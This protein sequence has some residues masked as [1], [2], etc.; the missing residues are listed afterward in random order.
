MITEEQRIAFKKVC[1]NY[2]TSKIQS[3]LEDNNVKDAKGNTHSASMITNV[4]NGLT[5]HEEIEDA[6]FE[7][8]EIQLKANRRK[9][10]K[11]KKL[12]KSIL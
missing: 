9:A 11:K 6:L 1:G 3:V 10:A 7:V 5:E 12:I 8:L 2:Y 4:F